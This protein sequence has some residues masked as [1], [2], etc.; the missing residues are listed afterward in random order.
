MNSK[1]TYA[2]LFILLE[3]LGFEVIPAQSESAYF[4]KPT[5]S[6]LR[7]P[8]TDMQSPVA[9]ADLVSVQVRLH[10]NGLISQELWHRFCNST[11]LDRKTTGN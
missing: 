11:V 1:P 4:H 9:T 10:E 5:E 2:D 8:S 3:S 7:F 6:L